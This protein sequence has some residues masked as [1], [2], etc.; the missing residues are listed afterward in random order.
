MTQYRFK[1]SGANRQS[2]KKFP[3]RALWLVKVFVHPPTNK[4]ANHISHPA[5]T[6]FATNV[7][8]SCTLLQ[9]ASCKQNIWFQDRYRQVGHR[10][11]HSRWDV[12]GVDAV[13]WRIVKDEGFIIWHEGSLAWDHIPFKEF[14]GWKWS[15]VHSCCL[16]FLYVSG[17]RL[18]T[19]QQNHQYSLR[20]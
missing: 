11:R 6:K 7:L 8:L 17:Q 15:R 5:P 10:L 9:H 18:V 20:W 1:C 2:Q 12:L 19:I 13:V 16:W 4:G 14:G 3:P